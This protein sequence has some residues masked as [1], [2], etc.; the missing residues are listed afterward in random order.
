MRHL[1][2]ETACSRC[3]KELAM[4]CRSFESTSI[5]PIGSISYATISEGQSHLM[6]HEWPLT[7]A[8]AHPLRSSVQA[9]GLDL[10]QPAVTT[11]SRPRSGP[12]MQWASKSMCEQNE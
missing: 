4:R 12:W 9:G 11:D 6:T 8:L 1:V 3:S 5:N 2:G 10:A 7:L